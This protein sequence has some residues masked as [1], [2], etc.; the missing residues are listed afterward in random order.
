MSAYFI[1]KHRM[2]GLGDCMLFVDVF[3]DVTCDVYI[4]SK[5]VD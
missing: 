3:G 5:R 1:C 4:L 2:L